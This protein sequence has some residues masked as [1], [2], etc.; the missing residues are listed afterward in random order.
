MS[1]T[2][3]PHSETPPARKTL[4]EEWRGQASSTNSEPGI[5]T[6]LQVLGWLV[7]GSALLV[8]IIGGIGYMS[9]ASVSGGQPYAVDWSQVIAG[10]LGGVVLLGLAAV[11]RG[12]YR[13]EQAIKL[14]R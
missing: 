13:I 5:C 2:P 10:V 11:V 6:T 3:Y 8:A 4:S 1:D 9:N 12:L 14:N 7:I